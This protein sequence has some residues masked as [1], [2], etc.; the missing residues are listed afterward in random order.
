MTKVPPSVT[1]SQASN[2][3]KWL[4]SAL[5]YSIHISSGT[6]STNYILTKAG[7][8]TILVTYNRPYKTLVIKSR[9]IYYIVVK[10]VSLSKKSVEVILQDGRKLKIIYSNG[11]LRLQF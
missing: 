3:A 9:F 5:G 2:L 6:A 8:P 11:R 4:A 1:P 10:V 7:L